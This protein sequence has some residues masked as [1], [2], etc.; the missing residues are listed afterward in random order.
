MQT[1]SIPQV[2]KRE[3]ERLV[4]PGNEA[5]TDIYFAQ[6]GHFE[7]HVLAVELNNI[8]KII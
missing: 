8:W 3:L 7:G 5:N 6:F 4:G 1:C 2:S